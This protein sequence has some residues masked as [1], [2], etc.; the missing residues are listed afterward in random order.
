M[1]NKYAGMTVNER[2]YVSELLDEFEKAIDEKNTEEAILWFE[3]GRADRNSACVITLGG[4]VRR[5]YQ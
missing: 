1:D 4:I 3:T 5:E 2:L